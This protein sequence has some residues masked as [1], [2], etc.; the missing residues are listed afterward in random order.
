M[1]KRSIQDALLIEFTPDRWGQVDRFQHFY[2][3]TYKWDQRTIDALG[4]VGG[5]FHRAR[6]LHRLCVDFA[7][8]LKEDNDELD[9]KGY[10]SATR[11]AELAALVEAFFTGIYSSVDCA[12]QVT[13]EVFKKSRGVPPGSTRKFF[14]NAA[15]GK[16]DQGMPAGIREAFS[17]APWYHELRRLRDAITHSDVGSCHLDRVTAKVRYLHRALRVDSKAMIIEDVLAK[18]NEVLGA[19]NLFNGSVFRDLNATLNDTEVWQLCGMFQ[20]RGY[21]RFVRPSE[22]VDFGS[23]RCEAFEWFEKPENPSC[24]FAPECEAYKRAKKPAS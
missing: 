24:P 10:S 18:M 8:R 21:T 15:A 22:A 17:N 20:G 4:G 11:G 14:Q 3:G 2:Y 16:L 9:A 12:C 19:V 5:H 1:S 7:P 13:A 6:R 23:G